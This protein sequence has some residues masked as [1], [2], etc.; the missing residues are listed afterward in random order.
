M[1]TRKTLRH[2]EP[3][4]TWRPLWICESWCEVR[5]QYTSQRGLEN[6]WSFTSREVCEIQ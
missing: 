5:S 3:R 4:S 6:H 2:Y 1:K